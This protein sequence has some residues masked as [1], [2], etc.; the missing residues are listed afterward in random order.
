MGVIGR[1]RR[2]IVGRG[3]GERVRAVWPAAEPIRDHVAFWR[4]VRVVAVEA[5]ERAA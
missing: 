2:A 5:D 1:L 4:G 3:Q